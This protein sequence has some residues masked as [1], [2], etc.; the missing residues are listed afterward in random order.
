LLYD[1][2]RDPYQTPQRVSAVEMRGELHGFEGEKEI[3]F[4]SAKLEIAFLYP[5]GCDPILRWYRRRR[6]VATGRLS[7]SVSQRRHDGLENQPT[8]RT[9]LVLKLIKDNFH[10]GDR[11]VET[12]TN[13]ADVAAQAFITPAGRK[14]LLANKRNQSI[15][16][17]LPD[18]DKAMALTVDLQTGDGPHAV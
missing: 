5:A 16:L 15:E 17:P 12:S 6:R 18:S 10:P 14:L 13:S 2:R 9:V 4:D 1:N 11:L 7:L 3:E 8:Q